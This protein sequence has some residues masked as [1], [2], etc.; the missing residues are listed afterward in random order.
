MVN[1]L[2]LRAPER[3]DVD[4]MYVWENSDDG[5]MYGIARAPYSKVMLINYVENYDANP[6]SSGQLRLLAIEES[7]GRAVGMVDLYDIDIYHQRALVGII[8]DASR[9]HEGVGKKVLECLEHYCFTRLGLCQLGAFVVES[10]VPSAALF[11]S[12][13]YSNVGSIP[14]WQR[15]ASGFES[16]RI[17]HKI[18]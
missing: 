2:I 12:A 9:R 3:D 10:N 16:I 5:W 14:Q 6:Y 13:G 8:V 11:E 18:L 15:T 1:K 4:M 17:Y 7:S